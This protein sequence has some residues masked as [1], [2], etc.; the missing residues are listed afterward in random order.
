MGIIQV[1]SICT[2]DK[3]LT[4]YIS[5]SHFSALH[6]DRERK[7]N[8]E[9]GKGKWHGHS[10]YAKIM[11]QQIFKAQKLWKKG[12]KCKENKASFLL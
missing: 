11:E 9:Y 1:P 10:S 6:P 3:I 12:K 4:I 7:S 8:A 2:A 5:T